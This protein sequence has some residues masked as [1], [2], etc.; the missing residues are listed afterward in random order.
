MN[1]KSRPVS[2]EDL[3]R[4]KRAEQPPPEFWAE[5]EREMRVKQLAAIVEPRPWWAS[6]IRVGAKVAH[7]QLPLGA[8]AILALSF[9]T[10][11]EYRTGTYPPRIE[12]QLRAPGAALDVATDAAINEPSAEIEGPIAEV[13]DADAQAPAPA[14]VVADEPE[15]VG[16]VSHAVPLTGNVPAP[17]EPSPSELYIAANLAAAQAADPLIVDEAF[18]AAIRPA[19]RDRIRDPLIQVASLTESRRSRLLT[20]ALPALSGAADVSV[21]TSARVAQRLTE[22]RLYDSISRIGVKANRVA[23]KF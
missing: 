21:G 2:L 17:R 22:D 7:Y 4:V 1:S 18:G 3:L 12:P 16:R 15:A 23:I 6:F 14:P 13:S 11:R 20:T 5:F 8:A 10:I 9:V 19:N